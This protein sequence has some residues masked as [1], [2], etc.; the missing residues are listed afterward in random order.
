MTSDDAWRARACTVCA[1]P[2]LACLEPR[3]GA[4]GGHTSNLRF[5]NITARSENGGYVSG[6]TNGVYNVSFE[7]VHVTLD[8]WSNYSTGEVR[9]G[10][11]AACMH[12]DLALATAGPTLLSR[13]EG[14]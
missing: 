6:L 9:L 2:S 5:I 7:N 13:W 12:V 10:Y 11:V 4:F 8:H 14:G 1:H 3:S